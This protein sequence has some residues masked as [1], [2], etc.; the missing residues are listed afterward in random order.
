MK[1]FYFAAIA[2]FTTLSLQAQVRNDSYRPTTDDW[3]IKRSGEHLEFREP[4]QSSKL[5]ARFIDDQAL[6]LS[7]T[8]N[9][10]VDGKVGI[11]TTT[12]LSDIHLYSNNSFPKLRFENYVGFLST[13]YTQEIS[14]GQGGI[15]FK[16]AVSSS[17]HDGNVFLDRSVRIGGSG[18]HLNQGRKIIMTNSKGYLFVEIDGAD[19]EFTVNATNFKVTNAGYVYARQIEVQGSGAFPDYVFDEDYD[20]RPLA[21]VEQYIKENHHLPEVPS[22]AEVDKNGINLGQMDEILLKKVE[23]LTLYMIQLKKENEKLRSDLES[24]K[25]GQTLNTGK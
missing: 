17:K 12:P 18:I 5:W 20:L 23:E 6:H 11:G 4:E 19:E 3:E 16:F 2:V 13:Y 25:T 22:A 9:L 24:L 1:K 7:G 21:E 15:D 14:A 10:Y 8:P